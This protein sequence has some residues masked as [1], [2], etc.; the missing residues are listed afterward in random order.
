MVKIDFESADLN[1]LTGARQLINQVCK[2][3]IEIGENFLDLLIE[4]AL[5][6]IRLLSLSL[7][8]LPLAKRSY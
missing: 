6:Q 2:F 4:D 7:Y 5:N 3:A 8:E 1:L